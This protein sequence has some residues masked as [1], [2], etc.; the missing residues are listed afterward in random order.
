MFTGYKLYRFCTRIDQM[1]RNGK[2]L[3]V[4]EIFDF[5]SLVDNAKIVL[6]GTDFESNTSIHL[7]EHYLNRKTIIRI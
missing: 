5:I 4:P 1:V 7:A 2:S 6:I 3:I